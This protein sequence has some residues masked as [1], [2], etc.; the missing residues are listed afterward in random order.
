MSGAGPRNETSTRRHSEWCSL[1]P[2]QVL[3]SVGIP[4][5]ICRSV[6]ITRFR[7]ECHQSRR[8]S[9]W[10]STPLRP[11][12]QNAHGPCWPAG[13]PDQRPNYPGKGD[14]F[15]ENRREA[16]SASKN[17]RCHRHGARL[18]S[19]SFPVFRMVLMRYRPRMP[20]PR[21]IPH[22]LPRASLNQF[23]ARMIRFRQSGLPFSSGGAELWS[24]EFDLCARSSFAVESGCGRCECQL[25]YLAPEELG[26]RVLRLYF[27]SASKCG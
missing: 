13:L 17:L 2:G 11:A 10:L 7:V 19:P 1:C 27:E 16:Q 9:H 23:R 15:F 8:G 21:T 20:V 5:P 22:I 14:Q 3:F 25:R 4:L 18:K 6:P 12:V 24:W 26:C